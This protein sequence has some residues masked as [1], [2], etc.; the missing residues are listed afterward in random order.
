M[1]AQGLQASVES[2]NTSQAAR[3]W[4]QQFL[5]QIERFQDTPYQE[6][7]E[8]A[9][10]R[11]RHIQAIIEDLEMNTR[12]SPANFQEAAGIVKKL[13]QILSQED[14]WIGPAQK[15]LI[16]DARQTV[17]Q[18]VRQ[19]MAEAHQWYLALEADFGR[20]AIAQVAE[21]LKTPQPFFP[22]NDRSKLDDLVNRV[23]QRMDEDVVVRIETQFR[24]I[25][26]RTKR[27]QCLNRL[28]QILE[29]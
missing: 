22:E 9:N 12:K 20:G 6:G 7:L 10:E 3:Q 24:Q 18:Y 16:I 17:D 14:A 28:N 5:R 27:Q 8:S 26:D 29:E 4:Q 19:K 21:K 2:L 1:F 11:V 13:D 15:Q 23:Q 25:T